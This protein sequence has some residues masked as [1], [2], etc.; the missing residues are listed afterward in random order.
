M[1]AKL[2]QLHQGAHQDQQTQEITGDG[3]I[4]IT[5]GIVQITAS[6]AATITIPDPPADD[7]GLLIIMST[8]AQAHTVSNAAGSGFNAGGAGSDVATFGA[9]IGNNL[10]LV[11]I[12]G[13]WYVV[14][15]TGITLA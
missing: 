9:A 10:V 14:T 3:A 5:S 15:S 6:S 4:K 2:Y 8:T 7:D 12:K 11:A 13:K 1:T